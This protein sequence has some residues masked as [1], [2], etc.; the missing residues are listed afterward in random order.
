MDSSFVHPHLWGKIGTNLCRKKTYFGKFRGNIL[1]ESD[2][3][4]N[5]ANRNVNINILTT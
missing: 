4:V 3:L 2:I 5:F 1:E